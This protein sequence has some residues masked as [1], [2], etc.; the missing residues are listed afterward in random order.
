MT[1]TDNKTGREPQEAAPGPAILF[2][3]EGFVVCMKP[4]GLLS[5]SSP[6]DE[7]SMVGMLE[8]KLGCPVFPVHRLDRETSGLMVFATDRAEAARLSA[9]IAGRSGFSKEYLCAV[10]GLP[11][12]PEGEMRDLLFFDRRQN[13]SFVVASERKGVKEAAL[14]YEVLRSAADP[15]SGRQLSLVKVR[16]HTGR[17]HQIRVQFASRGMPLAGDRRYG[18]KLSCPT[19]LLSCSLSFPDREGNMLSFTAEMPEG[20]PWDLFG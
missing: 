15:A 12:P 6:G 9:L 1:E 20:S 14:S 18:S 7:R 2:S 10:E 16:L 4:A 8:E 3:G 13:R 19:A 5:E 11:D 17:T